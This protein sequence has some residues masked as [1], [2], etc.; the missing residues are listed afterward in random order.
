M[1]RALPSW[2]RVQRARLAA[3]YSGYA[4]ERDFLKAVADGCMPAPFTLNGADAWDVT[5]LDASIDAIKAGARAPR[6]W[7]EGAPARV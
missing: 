6:R 4:N 5:D 2:P 3:E 1:P 7:Q